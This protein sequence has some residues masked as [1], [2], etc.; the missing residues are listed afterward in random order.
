MHTVISGYQH[1]LLFGAHFLYS[2]CLVLVLAFHS[3]SST[4][5]L[6][7]SK[8]GRLLTRVAVQRRYDIRGA[9]EAF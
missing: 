1:I 6:I 5:N 8:W 3:L 7:K 2:A 4:H 9:Q